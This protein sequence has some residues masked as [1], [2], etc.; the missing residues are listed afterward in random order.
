MLVLFSPSIFKFSSKAAV[1]NPGILFEDEDRGQKERGSG[2]SSPIVRD[3]A[4]FANEWN[5][6]PH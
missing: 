3:S 4:Q 2:G 6:Y 5:P 1:A